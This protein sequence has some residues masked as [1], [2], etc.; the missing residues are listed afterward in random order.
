MMCPI[1]GATTRGIKMFFQ[2]KGRGKQ[3]TLQE[4]ADIRRD[5]NGGMEIGDVCAK[6]GIKTARL[7]VIVGGPLTKSRQGW[8]IER[9]YH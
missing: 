7:R 6:W 8:A 9:A 4:E 5:F 2:T 3:L 1:T